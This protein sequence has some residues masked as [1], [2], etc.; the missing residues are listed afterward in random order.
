[1]RKLFTSVVESESGR[2]TCAVLLLLCTYLYV[3]KRIYRDSYDRIVEEEEEGGYRSEAFGDALAGNKH[4]NL[5]R[6]HVGLEFLSAYACP[7][8]ISSISFNLLFPRCMA[9]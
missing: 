8:I 1:M 3:R 7:D 2:V 9:S 6:I 5:I 4:L